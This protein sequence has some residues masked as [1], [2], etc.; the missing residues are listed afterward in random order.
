MTLVMILLQHRQTS[1][2]R[3]DAVGRVQRRGNALDSRLLYNLD[4][5]FVACPSHA[6]AELRKTTRH[7]FLRGQR[8][9]RPPFFDS[10]SGYVEYQ[11]PPDTDL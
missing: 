7:W 10:T 1:R 8:L 9:T 3:Y 2:G 11:Y 4:N 6:L 5:H